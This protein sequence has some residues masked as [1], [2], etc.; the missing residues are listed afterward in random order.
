MK[1]HLETVTAKRSQAGS[2][3]TAAIIGA[4][5]AVLLVL[6]LT[7]FEQLG[8][9]VRRSAQPNPNASQRLD[10]AR[11][12]S[13]DIQSATSIAHATDIQ[14]SLNTSDG[15]PVIYNFDARTHTVSR[16]KGQETITLLT[17]VESASFSTYLQ[18]TGGQE[19]APA[20]IKNA[21]VVGLKWVSL[22]SNSSQVAPE[23][24]VVAGL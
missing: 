13:L 1:T 21:R 22:C 5:A 3:L 2:I 12:F 6:T 20:T 9:A 17:G 19:L 16:S 11:T 10:A 18:K 15:V 14:L 8:L 24:Q 4:S 7:M 23:I